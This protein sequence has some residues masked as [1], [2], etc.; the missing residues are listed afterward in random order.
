M[1]VFLCLIFRY[2]VNK[3]LPTTDIFFYVFHSVF[4][5]DRAFYSASL[6]FHVVIKEPESVFV[7][8]DDCYKVTY[9]H[10]SHSDVGKA[11]H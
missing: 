4:S 5:K 9:C 6:L 1:V 11:P 3:M 7:K 2:K 8:H 10:K